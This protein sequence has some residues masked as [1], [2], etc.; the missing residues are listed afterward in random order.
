MNAA[1]RR[2]T[3]LA[4]VEALAGESLA[5]LVQSIDENGAYPGAFLRALGAAGGFAA[6]VDREHGG[7][8][9]G[10]GAQIAVIDAVGATCGAT[11]FLVWAQSAAAGYLRH[12]GNRALRDGLLP[13]LARGERL[14]GTG[15]SNPMKHF[16][17]IEPIR[18][19]A[20]RAPG[21]YRIDGALPWVSNIGPG[22]VFVTAAAVDG[23]GG[24]G[25][26]MFVADCDAAGLR[27]GDCPPFS[28]LD[29]TRTFNCRFSGVFVPDAAVV[30]Q[31]EEFID[32]LRRI[33]PGFVLGQLGIGF[34]VAE[35]C[36]DVIRE[37]ALTHAHVND[38]LETQEDELAGALARARAEAK[39]LAVRAE[40]GEAIAAE[41][42]RLRLDAAELALK[43]ANAAVLHAGAKGFLKRHPAQ[44]RL[45]EAVFVAIVTPAIKHLR[46]ELGLR[47]RAT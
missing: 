28:A 30:A 4:E 35:G 43:A 15:M 21:G 13:A 44:R 16:A 6:A 2:E 39:T 26:A 10:L 20:T 40:A 23:G 34:G 31:P 37:S 27:L 18:L 33:R 45:R 9:L 38:W 47:P 14:G 12:S 41:A 36:I 5:P 3:L 1:A 25:Y 29:G 11:A 32:Y 19:R 42:L 7:L 46:K 17:G 22:N 8:G 24:G